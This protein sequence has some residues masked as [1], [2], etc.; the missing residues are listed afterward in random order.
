VTRVFEGVPV[1]D[2]LR[3]ELRPVKGR[4][5]ILSGVEFVGDRDDR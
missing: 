2:S 3:I 5:P 4:A 1:A